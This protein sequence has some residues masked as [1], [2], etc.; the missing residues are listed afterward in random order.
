MNEINVSRKIRR[1]RVRQRANDLLAGLLVREDSEVRAEH[2]VRL[3]DRNR[4][5]EPLS[6]GRDSLCR[7]TVIREESVHLRQ[8]V[9]SR[10]DVL[11]NLSRRY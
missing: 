6:S 1:Y 8:R 2:L 9:R 5:R 10:L 11:L 7:D 3:A 4:E